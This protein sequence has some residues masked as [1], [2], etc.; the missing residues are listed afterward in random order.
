MISIGRSPLF[1]V[2][3]ADTMSIAN[4]ASS[5]KSNG[6]ICGET[7]QNVL[8]VVFKPICLMSFDDNVELNSTNAKETLIVT[9]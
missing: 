3:V 1:T 6:T 5:P 7:A 4:T 9:R 8:E 2:Q